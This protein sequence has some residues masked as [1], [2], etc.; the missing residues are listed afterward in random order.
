MKSK[1]EKKEKKEK[2]EQNG[3]DTFHL[4]DVNFKT[5]LTVKFKKRK[6]YQE[7][8]PKKVIA[9]IPGKVR[10][11]FVKKGSRVKEGDKLLV[12]EAMKM[13]N[14]IL[15]PMKGTIL[16]VYVATGISVA[17]DALLIEFE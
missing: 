9:F 11:V 14:N 15:S 10:K 13:N 8:D 7:N 17:K 5:Y 4:N 3:F 6:P 2:K 1:S 16:E 12:L